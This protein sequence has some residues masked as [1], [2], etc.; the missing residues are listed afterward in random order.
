MQATLRALQ[1]G[2]TAQPPPAIS[3]ADLQGVV[4]FPDYWERETR[5][6]TKT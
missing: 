3:F 2:S 1:P 6:Q 5:Y 4:G